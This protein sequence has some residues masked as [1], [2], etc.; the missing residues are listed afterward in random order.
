MRSKLLSLF[1]LALATSAPRAEATVDDLGFPLPP[2]ALTRLGSLSMRQSG[3][4]N[5]LL[6]TGD[7]SRLLAAGTAGA[8][9]SWDPKTGA[10]MGRFGI[11]SRSIVSLTKNQDETTFYAGG[12][13]AFLARFRRGDLSRPEEMKT[14]GD[15]PVVSPA[16]DRICVVSE[17]QIDFDLL[18]IDGKFIKTVETKG[19][20]AVESVF[21]DD[22]SLL[23]VTSFSIPADK[24]K[25][26]RQPTIRI[27]KVHAAAGEDEVRMLNPP[28]GISFKRVRFLPDNRRILA[29]GIDGALRIIDIENMV[30]E[31]TVKF[32]VEA[33]TALAL[34]PDASIAAVGDGAGSVSV[35][36]V[37]GLSMIQNIPAHESPVTAIAL[38]T[39]GAR[40]ASGG[41]D[42]TVRVFEVETGE[43][44][45][46]PSGHDAQVSCVASSPDF[47]TFATGTLRGQLHVWDASTGALRYAI[48]ANPGSVN[49]VEF[50]KSGETII[51]AGQDGNVL[52]FD[53]K[54]G[55]EKKRVAGDGSAAMDLALSHD[56]SLVYVAFAHNQ[57]RAFDTATGEEKLLVDARSSSFL[58][59]IAASSD[60][61]K[62]ALG[63][64]AI[65]IIDPKGTT[66]LDITDCRAPVE[67]LAFAP[68]GATLVAG[69]ADGT[70]RVYDSTSGKELRRVQSGSGRVKRVR[71]SPDGKSVIAASDS[72]NVVRMFAFDTLTLERVLEG[73]TE[74]VLGISF[75]G[76]EK[77]A[78]A[79]ADST[80]LIWKR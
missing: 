2:G 68:D 7:D 65:R 26:H 50:S 43:Q 74:P 56:G 55:A 18:D 40:V 17:N 52:F 14:R 44:L 3:G 72:E 36:K 64:S 49:H 30:V 5:A 75:V 6:F 46:G 54:D 39:D 13:E 73:H 42:S 23:A 47:S 28:E 10:L 57:M 12:I 70:I 53:A 79:S 80:A 41:S 19:L 37:D 60:G 27:V 32:S 20:K 22:G 15:Q 71:I 45:A 38:S 9:Y 67:G 33:S 25:A 21:S 58:F 76:N 48:T 59:S 1:A 69:L 62:I 66:L 51:V 4:V 35:F 31:P 24:G 11:N 61:S 16:F 78:S 34:S 8:I 77:I 29:A 63:A